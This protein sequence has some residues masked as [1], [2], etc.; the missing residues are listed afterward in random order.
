MGVPELSQGLGY[1][2]NVQ[3]QP[4]PE[5][6]TAYLAK[7]PHLDPILMVVRMVGS[8]WEVHQPISL[9]LRRKRVLGDV[10][11]DVSQSSSL[12]CVV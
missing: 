9:T 11:P 7:K 3:K 12:S 2:L 4:V 8:Q 10:I 6:C 1:G 5:F